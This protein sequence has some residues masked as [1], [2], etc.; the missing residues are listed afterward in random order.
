MNLNTSAGDNDSLEEP[1][2]LPLLF[3]L[4]TRDVV[5]NIPELLVVGVVDDTSGDLMLDMSVRVLFGVGV[6][7]DEA[8]KQLVH[9]PVLLAAQL[10]QLLLF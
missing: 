10:L 4:A 8:A 7:D 9:P 3:P 2:P 1:L 6:D 5:C